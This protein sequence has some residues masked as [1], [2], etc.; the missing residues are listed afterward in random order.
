MKAI[1]AIENVDA[2]EPNQYDTQ[3]K[4]D[5]L[6]VL[7]GQIAEEVFNTHE[8]EEHSY[9]AY[10]TGS[11]ELLIKPPYAQDIY[12]NYLLAQIHNANGETRRYQTAAA[13][14]NNAYKLFTSWHNRT[15]M[16]EWAG[17]FRC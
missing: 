11:E 7:D 8:G 10:T 2:L 15:H 4:L 12:T 9:Q 13:I 1:E 6:A 5:W 17:G 16:P 3:Q 14:Y